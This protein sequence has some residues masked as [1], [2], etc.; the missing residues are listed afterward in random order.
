MEELICAAFFSAM[1]PC[2][3]T[4]TSTTAERKITKIVTLGNTLVY[5]KNRI[6]DMIKT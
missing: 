3:Y 6:Y 5:G 2:D 1:Q 4:K